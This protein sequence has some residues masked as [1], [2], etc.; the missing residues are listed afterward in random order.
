M[1]LF[2]YVALGVADD[3]TWKSF[4]YIFI[5]SFV[6]FAVSNLLN[7]SSGEYTWWSYAFSFQGFLF[8]P[9]TWRLLRNAESPWERENVERATDYPGLPG[10][11][12]VV[13]M[14]PWLTGRRK[15]FRHGVGATGTLTVLPQAFELPGHDLF[16]AGARFGVQAR[17]ANRAHGDDAALDVRGAS[18]KVCEAGGRPVLELPFVTGSF[19]L[20]S[21]L[22][23][24]LD[25]LPRP[26]REGKPARGR[27]RLERR[28]RSDREAFEGF[29]GGLRRAPASFTSLVYHHQVT[30][31]WITPRCEQWLCRFRLSPVHP[32]DAP[33]AGEPDVADLETPWRQERRADE[34][35]GPRYLREELEARIDGGE[36]P[37]MQLEVQLHRLLPTDSLEWYD[38]TVEWRELEHP[39]RPLARLELRTLLPQREADGLRFDP[40]HAPRS[41]SI[42]RS[43]GGDDPRALAT[44]QA[45]VMRLVGKARLWRRPPP[46]PASSPDVP[47]DPGTLPAEPGG[48]LQGGT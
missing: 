32:P 30:R 2:S 17:F 13:R 43:E 10:L 19:A 35:R 38:P 21:N 9:L 37:E 25:V 42:P 40:S 15:V 16:V 36:R 29:V 14:T 46:R 24:F 48:R 23:S 39:W 28:M 7:I 44:M 11:W 8:I 41:L 20:V 26:S 33:E 3:R 5:A 34:Q 1:A 47:V 6:L 12:A 4:A 45:R 27:R 31:H 22:A 18:L